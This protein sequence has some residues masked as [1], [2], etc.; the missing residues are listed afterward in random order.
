MK[1]DLSFP[2][3]KCHA[4]PNIHMAHNFLELDQH[5]AYPLRFQPVFPRKYIYWYAAY[6]KSS[7]PDNRCQRSWM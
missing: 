5:R 4:L 1:T 7:I 6:P 3:L 2:P